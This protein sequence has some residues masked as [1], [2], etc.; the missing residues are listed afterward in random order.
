M[1]NINQPTIG[2]NL[3]AVQPQISPGQLTYA[4]NAM[5]EGFDGQS[6]TYQNE[7]ANELC[8]TLPVGYNVIGTKNVTALDTVYYFIINPTTGNSM[9]GYSTLNS[10][11]FNV[12]LDDNNY[13]S[14][15]FNFDINYP[16][17]KIEVKTTNCST[18]LY[19]T[20]RL[21]PRRYIDLTNLPW[22][23]SLV[24]GTFT[25]LVG[26]IDSNK[27]LVQPNFKVPVMNCT[28]VNVGG[29]LVEGT[30]QF[31][32]QYADILSNGYTSYYSVTNEVRIFL[33]GKIS[34]NFNDTT[35]KCI[36]VDISN[37]DTTGL[38]EYFNIAV[39][40]TINGISSVE[41]VDT[42]YIDS[43]THEFVYTGNE[44][45]KAD[46]KLTIS[47]ILQQNNYYDI[48][49]DL[50][51][52]DNVL[53][54]ADLIKEDD[55]SYQKIWNQVAVQWETWR[56]PY[57]KHEGY[58]NGA[59]C[60]NLQGYMRDEVYPL[61]GCFIF[62]NGKQSNRFHIPG[63]ASTSFDMEPVTDLEGQ[64]GAS[65]NPCAPAPGFIPTWKVY[66][67]GNVLGT[68]P[69]YVSGDSCYKGPVEYGTMG[70]WESELKYPNKPSIWGS[71]ANTPIRHH[72]FPDSSI[73]HI[74]DENPFSIG[75]DLYNQYEHAIYP[76]GIKLDIVQLRNII[77]VS[78]D[79][80]QAQKDQIVGFKIM[81][82]DRVNNKAIIAKGMLYNVGEYTKDTSTYYYPNYPFN[83][84]TPDPFISKVA[85]D[86]KSG[87]HTEDRQDKFHSSRFTF[88]SPDTSFFKPT[89]IQGSFVK[90]EAATYGNCKAH[91][92][93][94]LNNAGQKLRTQKDL[95][96]ALVGAITSMFGIQAKLD[97][98][99]G[100]PD[101]EV[102]IGISPSLHF[103]NF[104]P[105]F[106]AVLDII[107]KLIPYV[108]YGW[109][110]N[111]VGYYGNYSTAIP[112][113]NRIRAINYGGYINPG[114]QGTFGDDH[115]INNTFRESSVYLSLNSGFAPTQSINGVP[116]D[117]SRVIASE[118]GLCGKSSNFF[119]NISSY[120]GSVK[121][122]LPEQWGEVFSYKA[123]D[124]G[125]YTPFIDSNG[126]LIDST[127]TVFGGDVFI[128][129]FA[130]KRKH[131]FFLKSSVGRPDGTDIDYDQDSTTNT[132]TGNVGY[133]IWYYSTSNLPVNVQSGWLH[134]GVVNLTNALNNWVLA[135]LTAGLS[136]FIPAIQTLLGLITDGLLETLGIK[137]VNLDCGNSDDLHEKGQAYL[138]AYG[139][140][141][142]FCE[143]EVN[144]DM[145]QATNIR[146]G[147]FYPE[148]STD[149]PD[150]W[151]AETNT[152]IAYDN[153]YTY[154]RTYSKEN[155]ETF[156]STLRPDWTPDN[157]CFTQFNNRVIWSDK[158]SLEET[159]NN[160]LIYRPAAS[161]DL[162]KNYGKLTN[163]DGLQD[164]QVLVRF[165]NN[166][167]LYNALTTMQVSQGPAAYLGNT[168]MFSGIPLELSRTD[169][170]N[171]G[172]QNSM[173]LK[174][175][176]GN[177]WCDA[178]RGEVVLLN[179][180]T[181]A[182][183]LEE[184]GF[185]KWMYQNLPFKIL[186]YFPDVNTDN[187]FNGIGLHGVYDAYY[188]RILITK[189]DYEPVD[190][191][192]QFDGENFY[193]DGVTTSGYN[194]TITT[195]I[196]GTD[197]CCPDGYTY[198]P[199]INMCYNSSLDVNIDPI[200][201]PDVV[202]TS[203]IPVSDK[204]AKIIIKLGDPQYF[205]NRSW[206]LS[207]SFK[208]NT[209][210]SW[211]SYIP[212]YYIAF[213]SRFQSGYNVLG[214]I[215]DHDYRLTNF[216]MFCGITYP[217]ILEYPFAY[218]QQD[219]ILQNIKDFTTARK[220]IDYLTFYEPDE[221][222]YFNK[223][224]IYN[225]QQCTGL[226]NLIPKT[227]N[228]LASYMQYPKFNTDSKDIVLVKSDNFF[229]YNTFWDVLVDKSIPTW[230]SG[231]DMNVEDKE[232]NHSN[233]NYANNSFKKPQIR[234]KDVRIRHILDD[235]NDLRLIS[236]F[237]I[238]DTTNSYK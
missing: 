83:D 179:G 190:S 115:P 71:I 73:T 31:A 141:Y 68:S 22:K 102:T 207:Y 187:N 167:L 165:Q 105:T 118:V 209:W 4:L 168:D 201:C 113:G 29:D 80:T 138:Y 45:S 184:K 137:L 234:A 86:Y 95:E 185:T 124:T 189:K 101:N 175:D 235:K 69:D 154:N 144:V 39:I 153:I 117:N 133:P 197:T 100:Y 195:I 171:V 67:T 65:E 152:S 157:P 120:Y 116:Y 213:Y 221:I 163:I 110:Y 121:R 58:F 48:A 127:T 81:R 47:D 203:I 75:T 7:Q 28:E 94:V 204:T 225:G 173:F 170:G 16:I 159:K 27:L 236:K 211:H 164:N 109:Q 106:N 123:I 9:V 6:I 202:S 84:Q 237:L 93:P 186:D 33:D 174:T 227:K 56:I 194:E 26:Q 85:V 96:I 99:S 126:N 19:W 226:L 46:I 128:N 10:C 238:N 88:H 188:S 32:F 34:P 198:M 89:G 182:T 21:N 180:G 206:T 60:A 8:L 143:S 13:G 212:D 92:V 129:R 57:N 193:I 76:I 230:L 166:T 5:V 55:L 49:G 196:P 30:Y 131:S 3:E 36:T 66:N 160:Y 208:T 51:Q 200:Q 97:T 82:G 91:F 145:R 229:N 162:K 35:S 43:D 107:D 199:S 90:L 44:N 216:N 214:Q 222:L 135:L 220:V 161:K 112:V 17:H 98:E 233:M 42:I 178:K 23:D 37:I 217:Y 219:E 14:D 210:V 70:Y 52:V 231:C 64:I 108:N 156:F 38:H 134:S 12:L 41:L 15:L 24:A 205:C 136:V 142:Y 72:K 18:Q 104:F 119:R 158:S 140:P 74:H 169:I 181:N 177:I 78:T 125:F 148:V 149:I 40:K 54:W 139:V 232:L 61:E 114:L 87:P 172:S 155:K 183:N 191:T 122:Y 223:A 62:A 53:V 59:N 79:L 192:L 218:K 111:G 77:A 228:N 11:V 147:N 63:R 224:V 103:E 20:D 1:E 25:P 50:T 151:L 2:L 150:D 176:Y 130:L 132:Q 146:E 215:Y